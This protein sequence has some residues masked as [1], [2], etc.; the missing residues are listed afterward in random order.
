[1]LLPHFLDPEQK[2]IALGGHG[3]QGKIVLIEA[4]T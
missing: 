1:M 2:L 4:E 3:L